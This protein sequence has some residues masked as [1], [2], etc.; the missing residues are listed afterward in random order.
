MKDK[1]YLSINIKLA[2]YIILTCKNYDNYNSNKI[3]VNNVIA[4]IEDYDDNEN[5]R[6]GPLEN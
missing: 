5:I 2:K 3:D 6:K 4:R 1:A